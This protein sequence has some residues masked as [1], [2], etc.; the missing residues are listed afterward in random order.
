MDNNEMIKIL[1]IIKESIKEEKFEKAID[2][3]NKLELELKE[4]KDATGNYIDS[5]INNLK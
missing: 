5:L 4:G 3:I 2:Y 1:H